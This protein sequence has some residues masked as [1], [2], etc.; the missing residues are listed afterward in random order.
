MDRSR[1]RPSKRPKQSEQSVIRTRAAKAREEMMTASEVTTKPES[2]SKAET[3]TEADSPEMTKTAESEKTSC[4]EP[5]YDTSASRA[6]VDSPETTMTVEEW[7]TEPVFE[8]CS[9]CA[10]P[11]ETYHYCRACR[12]FNNCGD[13]ED[14]AIASR[15][16]ADGGCVYEE[17]WKRLGEPQTE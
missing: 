15:H 12:K 10:G 16:Y 1:R 7:S 6:E 8:T 5:E 9:V 2:A 14:S 4:E 13:C 17:Q 11:P 3:E